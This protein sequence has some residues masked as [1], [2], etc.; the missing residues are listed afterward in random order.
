MDQPF[1]QEAVSLM[2]LFAFICNSLHVNLFINWVANL[3][4]SCYEINTM[5]YNVLLWYCVL[6]IEP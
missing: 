2:N 4:L 5:S 1:S 3:D 6:Q